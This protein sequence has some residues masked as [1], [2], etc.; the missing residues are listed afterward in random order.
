MKSSPVTLNLR[1]TSDASSREWTHVNLRK[2]AVTSTVSFFVK[3][4]VQKQRF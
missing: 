4:N 2:L 1:E 3:Y